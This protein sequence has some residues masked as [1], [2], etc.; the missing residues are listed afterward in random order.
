M[1][2]QNHISFYTR[3]KK[4]ILDEYGKLRGIFI[5]IDSKDIYLESSY[6]LP[7]LF[8]QNEDCY[9]IPSIYKKVD[10]SFLKSISKKFK[11][12]IEPFI[13]QWDTFFYLKLIQ[14]EYIWYVEINF[15]KEEKEN[16]TIISLTTPLIF[17]N[18]NH[19]I[20]ID[21]DSKNEKLSR[22]LIDYTLYL[23]SSFFFE[24]QEFSIFF[25]NYFDVQKNYIYPDIIYE[26]FDQNPDIYDFQKHILILS[27]ESILQKLKFTIQYY[28]L[29]KYSELK[30]YKFQKILPQ[31]YIK[32]TDF[33]SS[34]YIFEL[35]VFENML[36][37][38]KK[39]IFTDSLRDFLSN[40][41]YKE[42]YWYNHTQSPL[43]FPFKFI[44]IENENHGI[45]LSLFWNKYNYIP[46]N[47]NIDIDIDIDLI[48]LCYFKENQWIYTKEFD[49]KKKQ[50][51]VFIV[52]FE[53]IY[54]LLKINI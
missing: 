34:K 24:K 6:P 27:S 16:Y 14:F 42:G 51:P 23:Y 45:Q 13:Y 49:E 2:I 7:P 33:F 21:N 37:K 3:I 10:I 54:V 48:V 19:N 43:P 22:I 47:E 12:K 5:N 1:F 25:K 39:N 46:I 9:S 40:N 52:L 29:Y 32:N 26:H 50:I 8:I 41:N 18:H 44:Q 28:L 30:E 11:F 38:E 15:T 31:F 17:Y 35:N 53:K 4:Q 20:I 36:M